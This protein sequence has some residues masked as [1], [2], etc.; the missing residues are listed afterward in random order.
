MIAA[1][2]ACSRAA[3]V[4]CHACRYS[5]TSQVNL[6]EKIMLPAHADP[7]QYLPLAL[8]WSSVFG[9]V[10]MPDTSETADLQAQIEALIR[11][12]SDH[13]RRQLEDVRRSSADSRYD[14]PQQLKEAS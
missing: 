10:A 1:R 9:R 13:L 8:M 6:H 5:Q 3:K 2:R 14:Q 7:Q 12:A 11:K 4:P